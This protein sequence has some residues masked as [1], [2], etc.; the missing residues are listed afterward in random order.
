[1]HQADGAAELGDGRE[2]VRVE[3][4][5][6][7]IVDHVCAGID[8]TTGDRGA[9]GVDADGDVAGFGHAAEDVEG[10]LEA[11]ELFG[12]GDGGGVRSGGLSAE[13]EDSSSGL[14]RREQGG[15]KGRWIS[16]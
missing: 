15:A 9:V 16:G 8:G 14:D 13:V 4:A 1:M 6:A 3:G 11:R 7:D 10:G 2:H 5:G 12:G